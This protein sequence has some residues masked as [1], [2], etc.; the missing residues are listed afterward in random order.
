[1]QSNDRRTG[2]RKRA[3][4]YFGAGQRRETHEPLPWGTAPLTLHSEY[5]QAVVVADGNPVRLGRRPLHV[6]DLPLGCVGQDRVLD[7]PGHLLDVPDEGLM[8]IRWGHRKPARKVTTQ[9]VRIASPASGQGHTLQSTHS[10]NP[11][12]G[13][14][15]DE[16]MLRQVPHATELHARE[17]QSPSPVSQGPF[18]TAERG[19][20]EGLRLTPHLL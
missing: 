17:W 1:M 5:L 20:A 7:G 11:T 16:E 14:F 12:Q 10:P 2:H 4:S 6:V 9:A 8:V 19:V 18:T 3:S 15:N 13:G